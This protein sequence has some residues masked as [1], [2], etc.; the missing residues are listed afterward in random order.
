MKKQFLILVTAV[1]AI[2][3][4]NAQSTV[5]WYTEYDKALEEARREEKNLFVLIT[6]PS[7]CLW[8]TRLEENVLSKEHF[9]KYQS[10][11]FISLKLLDK[12]NGKRN[13]ELDNFD[14]SGYPSVF[15]YDNEGRFIK[16]IY[17]QESDVMLASMSKYKDA[18]GK[19]RPLLKDLKLPE[20]YTYQDNGGGEYI[21]NGNETWT[22]KNSDSEVLYRQT[23]YDFDYIYLELMGGDPDKVHV[24][25]LPMNG[26]DRHKA[27]LIEEKW[28]WTDLEDV[29][30]I[31]GDPFF[32]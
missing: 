19:F 23:R 8:C 15:L 24:I 13:P 27:D 9:Q 21:N 32:D 2:I 25:A 28:V 11:N 20:K 17:T 3:T 16:N 5:T 12:I 18:E 26:V 4:I 1:F 7:W 10:E 22:E 14:F 30:R 6:A 29:V 31:G